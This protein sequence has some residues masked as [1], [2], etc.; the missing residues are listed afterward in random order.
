MDFFVRRGGGERRKREKGKERGE[1]GEREK[2]EE[3]EEQNMEN[4]ARWG[5]R[6][7]D[8]GEGKTGRKDFTLAHVS[9]HLRTA[10]GNSS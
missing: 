4:E 1:V 2:T 7:G 3:E 8:E 6:K 10:Q 9:V 5:E